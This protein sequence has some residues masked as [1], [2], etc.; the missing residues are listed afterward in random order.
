VFT[1]KL[2]GMGANIILCDPHRA[3]ITGPRPLRGSG[4]NHPTS[5]RDGDAH[6]RPVRRGESEIGNV[7]QIDRGYERIDER[8]RSLGARIE[9]QPA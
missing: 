9:R 3:V 8:L 2:V 6:R 4:S 5:A 1:D 7:R